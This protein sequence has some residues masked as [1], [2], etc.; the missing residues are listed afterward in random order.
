MPTPGLCCEVSHTFENLD[1]A[2]ASDVQPLVEAKTRLNPETI[3]HKCF[4]GDIGCPFPTSWC[5]SFRGFMKCLQ[6]TLVKIPHKNNNLCQI[7]LYSQ[8]IVWGHVP[9]NDNLLMLTQPLSSMFVY[10]V[11]CCYQKQ[12]NI[13]CNLSSCDVRRKLRL[14]CSLLH[15]TIKHLHCLRDTVVA[16]AARARRKLRT[17]YNWNGN[18]LIRDSP[19]AAMGGA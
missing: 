7:Q 17:V 2:D 4:K 13:Q 12:N 3:L 10:S 11:T 16:I 19:S 18:M 15:P 5:D 14:L 8:Q 9:L 1:V 6:Q